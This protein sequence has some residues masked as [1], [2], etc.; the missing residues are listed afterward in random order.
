[1]NLKKNRPLYTNIIFMII[2]LITFV[3]DFMFRSNENAFRIVLIG[4]TVWI[5]YFFYKKSF[6]RKSVIAFNSIFIFILAAMYFGSIFNFYNLIPNYDKIL[7][8]ISG[9][10]IA[11]IG[12][13][14]FLYLSNGRAEGNF[15]P[16]TGVWF[17]II[18]AIAVAGIWEMWEF[19]TDR[20]LGF[21]SQ[22]NSVID[23][24]LDIISGTV[25]GII[26]NIPIYFY[27]KGK[28]IK[29]IKKLIEEMKE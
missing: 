27:I 13:V 14:F 23:T 1:M 11:L 29:F 8:L 28:K 19:A 2:L 3:Y 9:I 17:S 15:K 5:M 20:L 12:F 18:F 24:M 16:M 22:N 25:T 7:H 6:L 4:V 26:T 21:T 10:I